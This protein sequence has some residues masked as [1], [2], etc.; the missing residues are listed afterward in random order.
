MRETL[1]RGKRKDNGEWIYG[2]L[3]IF[4]D[5]VLIAPQSTNTFHKIE[6]IP[7]TVGQFTGRLDKF[8]TMVYEGD[9]L[10]TYIYGPDDFVDMGETCVVLFDVHDQ[11]YV[12]CTK[13]D[14]H[15]RYDD[16]GNLGD[17]KYYQVIGNIHDNPEL[18]KG[19]TNE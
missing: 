1:F 17:P 11:A 8:G 19:E 6:V 4:W 2:S 5:W 14:V 9:V 3:I 13:N 7:E 10:Q 18:L 15:Y 16:F 12:L